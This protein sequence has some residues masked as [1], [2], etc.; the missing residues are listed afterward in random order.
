MNEVTIDERV[1]ITDEERGAVTMHKSGKSISQLHQ[2]L[3]FLRNGH[4]RILLCTLLIRIK[5]MRSLV[6]LSFV[7]DMQPF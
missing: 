1:K 4:I 6:S 7:R 5:I 3:D 2:M